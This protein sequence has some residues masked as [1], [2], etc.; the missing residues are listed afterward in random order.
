MGVGVYQNFFG[1]NGFELMTSS[2]WR[3][4]SQ[5]YYRKTGVIFAMTSQV[6]QILYTGLFFDTESQNAPVKVVTLKN[7]L[8]ML[9]KLNVG[10]KCR[11]NFGKWRR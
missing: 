11:A 10:Q 5:P 4:N 6:V 2:L 1:K 8:M 7:N 3:R 9:F